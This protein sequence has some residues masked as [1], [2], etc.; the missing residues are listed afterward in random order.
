MQLVYPRERGLGDLGTD[1]QSRCTGEATE[2]EAGPR[3]THPQASECQ[4]SEASGWGLPGAPGLP[5]LH[6]RPLPPGP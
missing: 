1:A 3:G 2:T 4:V 5:H 6:L